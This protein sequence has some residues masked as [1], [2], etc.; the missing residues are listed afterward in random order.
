MHDSAGLNA[1]CFL[2]RDVAERADAILCNFCES[3]PFLP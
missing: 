1:L 3:Q 2:V